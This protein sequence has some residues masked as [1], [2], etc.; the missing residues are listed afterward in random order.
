MDDP[1]YVQA[2]A[3]YDMLPMYMGPAQY[4]KFAHDTF[5]TEKALVEKLGLAKAN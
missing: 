3:R 1:S 2:L 5:A 4:T